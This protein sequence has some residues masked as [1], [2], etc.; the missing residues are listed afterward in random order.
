MSYREYKDSF[1]LTNLLF[2]ICLT[3]VAI[4]WKDRQAGELRVVFA[5]G[6]TP[7]IGPYLAGRTSKPESS[8]EQQDTGGSLTAVIVR[9][10]IP[11]AT[12]TPAPLA[13]TAPSLAA[14]TS[15]L[16]VYLGQTVGL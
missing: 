6:S 16:L 14:F 8:T 10:A 4:G 13:E 11:S 15:A 5:G 2:A 12:S 3:L 1:G 7:E 9:T